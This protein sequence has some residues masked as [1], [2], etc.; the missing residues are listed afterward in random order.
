MGAD[1]FKALGHPIRLQIVK[2][3]ERGERTV[4]EIVRAVGAE[5]SNVSRHL[6][7]LKQSGVLLSRKE[8]LRVFYSL[9]SAEFWKAIACVFNCVQGLVRQRREA[10]ESMLAETREECVPPP[11]ASETE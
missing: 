5:Q 2:Q 1:I 6:A 11:G 7:L 8:G 9:R 10:D 4:S 3:L